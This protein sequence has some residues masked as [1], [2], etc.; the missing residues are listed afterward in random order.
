MVDE[1]GSAWGWLCVRCTRIKSLCGFLWQI[2][3]LQRALHDREL[4][5][6]QW[7]GPHAQEGQWEA[8]AGGPAMSLTSCS[9][10]QSS[11]TCE[12]CWRRKVGDL[13]CEHA[14]GKWGVVCWWEWR[15]GC[16]GGS[17]EWGVLVGVGSGVC[18]WE[19]GVG[20]AS[21]SGEWGVLVGVGSGV[22]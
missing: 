5:Q 4:E 3:E 12:V 13:G 21:R 14:G 22:C 18:W 8:V 9:L 11:C 20:C 16:A 2:A 19:W 15:V 7:R 17:G 10:L 1:R 6:E